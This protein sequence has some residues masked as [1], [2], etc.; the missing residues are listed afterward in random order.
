MIRPPRAGAALAAAACFAIPAAAGVEIDENVSARFERGREIVLE[1][2]PEKGEGYLS[3]ARRLCGSP[4]KAAAL[5]A[6]NR[7]LPPILGRPL[8]VPWDLVRQEYRLLALRALFPEDRFEDGAWIHFPSAAKGLNH[9]ESLWQVASW[10]AGDGEKWLEIA[11]A[12]GLSG[13]ELPRGRPVRVP[14]ALLLEP[15]RPQE[16]SEDGRLEYARDA[17]GPVAVYRLRKG[18]AL[19]SA[20][21][22]RFTGLVEQDDV[23]R[24]VER[25][26][27][28]SGIDD[29]RK[30]PVGFPVKIPFDLLDTSYLP[31]HHPRRVLARI[32]ASELTSVRVPRRKA[33]LDGVHVILDPG[34]GG[35]DLG[36]RHNGVWE[37][38][39][40]YD[41]A[42]RVKKILEERTAATVHMT[43]RDPQQGCRVVDARKLEANRREVVATHPPYPIRGGRST[44]VSV[45]LRWYLAN[46]IYRSLVKKG[47]PESNV[48]FVS[49][50]AD[51]RHR[52]LRGA[53]V[54]IPGERYRRGTHAMRASS[55][56]RKFAEWRSGPRVSL[57][58]R[59]RL[60]DEVISRRLAEAILRAWRERKLPV[61]TTRPIRDHVVRSSR[62][63]RTSR[64]LPAVL[65][66][67]IVPG[68][69]LLELVNISN[70]SDAKLLADPAGRAR[71][72]ESL[73]EGLKRFFESGET[74][75]AGR[76]ARRR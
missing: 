14:E 44:K 4:D 45:N 20:V 34:H 51:A 13:P 68:K 19:Y 17:S 37:S 49:L 23:N 27:K 72:A 12:N 59:E 60:R 31:R 61:H 28:R 76:V 46:D 43:V 40:L 2:F 48:V 25:I 18:E 29:V 57:S 66:G 53:M 32:H 39:Y 36:A 5:Q 56:Y 54:Y 63:G 47:V 16:R 8:V 26:A 10:F 21:V 11:R 64:W 65:R 1:A 55:V 75:G 58:R 41:V 50:H 9:A 62:R 52:S 69:V 74:G 15:F 71:M 42:C 3:L 73:A 38:D 70:P 67:N 33:S 35:A 6:A 24:A 7:G 22:L 30:L